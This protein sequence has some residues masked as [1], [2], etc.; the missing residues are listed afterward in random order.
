MG[1][2]ACTPK[3][4]AVE[5]RRTTNA[6][7]ASTGDVVTVPRPDVIPITPRRAAPTGSR[8]ANCSDADPHAHDCKGMNDCK[9]LGGCKSDVN[10]CRGKNECK[11]KGGC[12]IE[13]PPGCD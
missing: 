13:A 1:L 3:N 6:P 12:R 5:P 7:L 9:G 2:A 11:G 8:N 4:D 10:D